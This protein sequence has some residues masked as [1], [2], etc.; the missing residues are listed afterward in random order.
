MSARLLAL[1]AEDAP[2]CFD[3]DGMRTASQ[4]LQYC[5]VVRDALPAAHS[6][7][8]VLLAC[9][10][11]YLF[12]AG[13]LGALE[14]GFVV[15]LPPNGQP[16]TVEALSRA[17]GVVALLHD[18]PGGAGL[19]L[20][21]L[22]QTALHSGARPLMPTVEEGELVLF[23][24]GSTGEPT[25]HRKRFAQLLAEAA[26]QV[27]AFGL[28]GHRVVAGVPPHHIYGLL[29]SVLVPLLSGGSVLR[30]TPL[31]P[32]ELCGELKRNGADVLVSVP[33]QLVALSEDH[34]L[35][36]PALRRLFCS[37]GPLPLGANMGL[38]ERGVAVTEI[39]GSTE[40]GGI[41]YRERPNA[42]WLPL[43][44]VTVSIG[45]DEVLC[46]DAPWLSADQPRPLRTADR[47][48]ATELGFRHLGRADAVTKIAGRRVDLGDVEA[49]LRA[50][51]QVRDARVIAV[52]A[53]GVRGL[54]LW[55][56]VESPTN[57]AASILKEAVARFDP[58]THPKRFRCVPALPRNDSGKV[59][60]SALLALFDTLK[61]DFESQ[62]D[63]SVRVLVP[64]NTG[65][66]RGHFEGDPILPGIVQLKNI[67]LTELRQRFPDL[68]AVARVTR[69]KFK[70]IV[71][72]GETLTLTLTRKGPLQV[73]FAMQVGPEA[74]C[75]GIFHFREGLTPSRRQFGQPRTSE[76]A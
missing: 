12:M 43:P 69:V 19:N 3:A 37:A 50:V 27:E 75:S 38:L 40:T 10:D 58:V 55:A 11:R 70:R 13:L 45:R 49:C 74:A 63:G 9:R 72:P 32:R 61:L 24:S 28:R 73:Q 25:A 52:D 68:G 5:A 8:S 57:I 4:L 62:P 42:S 67:A 33:P 48:Q 56:V 71:L 76:E 23:T 34:E 30:H 31:F 36:P 51:P 54:T 6:G 14:A 65:F 29:F 47:A 44:G 60:R 22:A 7:Q 20:A 66:V 39:L 2:V 64:R 18:V 26:S 41:A 1:H 35:T 46:V 16:E 59:T 21:Q 17:P 53:G 15:Q